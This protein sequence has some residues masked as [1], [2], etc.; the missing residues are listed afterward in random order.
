M[1][2]LQA[3]EASVAGLFAAPDLTAPDALQVM[4]IHKA[5][6]LEFDTVIVPGLAAGTGRDD[7]PLFLW[8]ETAESRLLLAPINA[9][10]SDKEPIY[11]LIRGLDKRRADHEN[12]HL[13]GTSGKVSA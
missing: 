7:R 4:T 6:G 5:K 13:A 9:T 2:D 12:V 1:G 8:M 3:F 10:G 11:E